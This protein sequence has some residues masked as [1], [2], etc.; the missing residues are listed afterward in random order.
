[1][2]ERGGRPAP[3]GTCTNVGCIPSKALL[4]SSEHFEH[5]GSTLPSTASA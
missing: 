5:A 1:V 3:G 2:E 4:Q